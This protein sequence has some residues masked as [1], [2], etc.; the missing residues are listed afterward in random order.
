LKYGAYHLANDY[1]H[2]ERRCY[3][4]ALKD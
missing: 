3:Y 2:D 1:F 4:S